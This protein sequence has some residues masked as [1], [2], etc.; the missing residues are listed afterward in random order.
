MINDRYELAALPLARGGMGEV[1]VGR[2]VKLEREVAVKFV[3][4][5]EGEDDDDLLRRFA[6]E[7]RITARLQHP[8]V[9]AVYDVGTHRGRPY[10]VMQRIR[11]ITI[12]DLIAEQER[13]SIEWSAAIAAQVCSVL[14]LAHRAS[15]VHRDLKPANLIL[16]P[17][18]TIKVLDFGLAVA[19][20]SSMFSHITRSGQTLGTPAYMAPEQVQAGLSGPASDL[21]AVGCLLFEMITGGAVFTG[22]TAYSVMHQQVDRAPTPLRSMR[23]EVPPELEAL[24]NELLHK[25]PEQRPAD[26]DAVY[27]RLLPHVVDLDFLPGVLHPPT[28]P[29]AVRMFATVVACVPDQ[30][31]NAVPPSPGDTDQPASSREHEEPS[32]PASAIRPSVQQAGEIERARRDAA[33]L[34]AQFRYSEAAD[35]L[36]PV[37][38]EAQA[39]LGE[40]SNEVVSVR[41]QL[42]DVLFD[43]GDF[44]RAVPIYDRLITQAADRIDADLLLRHRFRLATC[45]ALQGRISRALD[46]LHGL[47]VDEKA[48]YGDDDDRVLDIRHQI[49]L[50]Q[51]GAGDRADA[52]RSLGALLTDLERLRGPNAADTTKVRDLLTSISAAPPS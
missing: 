19:M 48:R 49:G 52:Q 29:N 4:L 37:L 33:E 1:W 41:Q 31:A 51:L 9:P 2:D 35:T 30:P 36:M 22:E 16:E 38:E 24:V 21:Y 5:P 23:P 18:G 44:G 20:D 45:H 46:E 42:A 15:L 34:V 7:S 28:L 6:R 43:G 32:P 50:L 11:G 39:T 25:H 8:G 3:R 47:L 26:A 17:E 40:S 10:L 13:L 12:A 27:R 14:A